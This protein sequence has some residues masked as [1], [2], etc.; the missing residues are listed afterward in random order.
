MKFKYLFPGLKAHTRPCNYSILPWCCESQQGPY[1]NKNASHQ[2]SIYKHRRE[3][4]NMGNTYNPVKQKVEAGRQCGL[5]SEILTKKSGRG[6]GGRRGER[7]IDI[8]WDSELHRMN[9]NS[10]KKLLLKR[11][12]IT[13]QWNSMLELH[14]F[15]LYHEPLKSHSFPTYLPDLISWLRD[16]TRWNVFC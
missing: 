6:R 15:L 13:S 12:V 9:E 11:L 2:N 3:S 16:K 8:S 10:A 4:D 5:C 14:V 1:A 7:L